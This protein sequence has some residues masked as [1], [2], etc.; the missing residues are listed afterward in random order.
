L[1]EPSLPIARTL[2]QMFPRAFAVYGTK[3]RRASLQFIA[4]VL[5]ISLGVSFPASFPGYMRRSDRISAG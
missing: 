1:H 4:R 3:G 2:P 5:R